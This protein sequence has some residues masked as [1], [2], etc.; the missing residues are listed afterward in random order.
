MHFRFAD[1]Q[2]DELDALASES[3]DA[4]SAAAADATAAA[5]GTTAGAS[6]SPPAVA[7]DPFLW[8][9][10]EIL[11][12]EQY[13]FERFQF[14]PETTPFSRETQLA[15]CGGAAA[16]DREMMCFA[17]AYKFPDR[18]Q[19]PVT[20]GTEPSYLWVDPTRESSSSQAHSGGGSGKSANNNVVF[21]QLHESIPPALWLP[22]RASARAI[23]RVLAEFAMTAAVHRDRHE[24]FWTRRWHACLASISR[25][26]GSA[27]VAAA[28]ADPGIVLRRISH[29]SL[30]DSYDANLVR[31]FH[32]SQE[33]FLGEFADPERLQ[34]HAD[35]CPMLFSTPHFRT[36][37]NLHEPEHTPTAVGPGVA[38]SLY[39]T[40][41]SKSLL[42]VQVHLATEVK[43]PPLEPDSFELLWT[44]SA[45]APPSKVPVFVRV[46]WPD[47]SKMSGGGSIARHANA[48]LGTEFAHD[49]PVDVIFAL[50]YLSHWMGRPHDFL[51]VHGM[52]RRLLEM[53]TA[54]LGDAAAGAGVQQPQ[55]L[56]ASSSSSPASSKQS[57][58]G[59][60]VVTSTNSV[61]RED[62]QPLNL[63]PGT[64]EIPSPAYSRD[65]R[66]A[67]HI[68]Y[69]AHLGDP[70]AA[71]TIAH[72]MRHPNAAVRLGCA[73]AAL[74]IGDRA[75]FK[76][77]AEAEPL[78]RVRR[79]LTQLVRKRKSRDLLDP[80]PHTDD[81]QFEFPPP[82]W[83]GQ[84]R[85]DPTSQEGAKYC[86]RA[87]LRGAAQMHKQ[88][89]GKGSGEDA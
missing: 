17:R 10:F 72:F 61:D 48:T 82:V 83:A 85:I 23:R 2:D 24:A 15:L 26:G 33:F 55:V 50:L 66:L 59:G 87:K 4:L 6:V 67:M 14:P 30:H 37:V 54:A 71:G 45:K 38:T 5:G 49:V 80:E 19:L 60:A 57:N 40:V 28:A 41:F 13:R 69:C 63:Y 77:I 56:G 86:A 3:G 47:N 89:K 64:A 16:A 74:E 88:A 51:G 36:A 76:R 44:D 39:R 81:G 21:I 70:L 65:E 18:R 84:K 27:A 46:V 11:P 42:F 8:L 53:E 78:G 68:Q 62:Q 31:E 79:V 32:N 58:A 12:E 52:R 1:A 73:K 29:A 9:D 7:V 20:V 34:Q 25:Q 22:V 75:L 43:L 35:L